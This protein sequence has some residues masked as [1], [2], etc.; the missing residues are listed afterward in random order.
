MKKIIYYSQTFSISLGVLILLKSGY[1]LIKSLIQIKNPFKI[2]FWNFWYLSI[3]GSTKLFVLH[4]LIGI[5]LVF[6]ILFLLKN[7]YK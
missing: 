2:E 1:S 3:Q 5:I 7:N 6:I 4:W